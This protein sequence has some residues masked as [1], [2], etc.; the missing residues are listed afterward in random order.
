MDRYSKYLA[1]SNTLRSQVCELELVSRLYQPSGSSAEVTVTRRAVCKRAT[2]K[3]NTTVLTFVDIDRSALD[4]VFPFETFT[5]ADFPNLH[6]DQVGWRVPQGVGT[7]TK[8]PMAWVNTTA[9]EWI[10]AGPKVIGSAGT[11]LAVYRGS[12]PGQGALV[13]PSEY[14]VGTVTGASAGELLS[15]TFAREQID[16]QGRPYVIE[17]DASLPGSRL[18]TTEASRVLALYGITADTASFAAAAAYDTTAGF[19]IDAIY[20]DKDRGRTG[21]AILEDL[22]AA[23]RCWLSPTSTGAWAVV[24]DSPKSATAEFDTRTDLAAIEEYGDGDVP[25]LVSIDY[26]PRTSGMED[27]SAHLERA[28]VATTGSGEMRLRNPYIRDHTVADKLISYWQKRLNTLR[29]ASGFIHAVQLANGEAIAVND[30]SWGSAKTFIITG[31][32]R[33]ADRN[34]VKLREYDASI[35]SYTAG[36]LPSDATAAYAPDVSYTPPAVPTGLTVV[37]QGASV[38]TD[39]TMT[40]F[41][42]IRATPPAANWKR[43]MAQATNSVTGEIYQAQL[44]LNGANYEARITGMRP[45]VAHTVIAWAVNA[46]NVDGIATASVGF[47]TTTFST[48]PA[49]PTSLQKVSGGTTADAN[50][51]VRAYALIRAVPPADYTRKLMAQVRD[52]TTNA[53][54]QAQLLLN[55]SNYEA[56][57]DGLLCNRAHEVIAWGVNFDNVDGG[58]TAAVAFTSDN[59]STAPGV[60]A[61]IAVAQRSPRQLRVAWASVSPTSGGPAIKHYKLERQVGSGSNPWDER[62]LVRSTDFV[63]DDVDIGTSYNYRVS[64]VDALDNVSG[65]RTAGAAVTPARIIDDSLIDDQGVSGPSIADASIN[66]TR[67]YSGTGSGS[68]VVNAGTADWAVTGNYAY[69]IRTLNANGGSL[70]MCVPSGTPSSGY[71]YAG[72]FGVNNPTGSNET[73]TFY[74]RTLNA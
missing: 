37:S 71:E 4:K 53:I 45:N 10:Y 16:F 26:R 59:Y 40:S 62:A 6:P 69:A 38:A 70:R 42:L 39:G 8:V 64:T 66:Q 9:T 55:A 31:I 52:T 35:Y 47:T 13:D 48:A 24:Q 29:E 33:P 51:V 44:L 12:Q 3:G 49:A 36:T 34:T 19:A 43:L 50:G 23:A 54:Q 1:I 41:A 18:P 72:T 73:I 21:M 11:V 20:G 14:V 63:D 61:S 7:V 60:P 65:V 22:L 32:N 68:L 74:Y 67:T 46:N 57:F 25:K 30:P 15:I 28:T 27:Y 5:V 58:V 17:I 2:R 56:R